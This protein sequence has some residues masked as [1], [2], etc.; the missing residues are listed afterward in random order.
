M[1]G[2]DINALIAVY[3]NSGY[4]CN[5]TTTVWIVKKLTIYL[6]K[7]GSTFVSYMNFFLTCRIDINQNEGVH[8]VINF[9]KFYYDFGI[10]FKYIQKDKRHQFWSLNMACEKRTLSHLQYI[11]AGDLDMHMRDG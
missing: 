1:W 9:K 10:T 4:A 11:I 5:R 2:T 3:E 6:Q 7:L 8:I